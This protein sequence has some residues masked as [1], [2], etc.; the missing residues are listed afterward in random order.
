[1]SITAIRKAF[2]K[3]LAAMPD[4]IETAW[5][6]T[7]FTPTTGV[8]YQ[9]A[10]LMPAEPSNPTISTPGN[11][12]YRQEGYFQVSLR[13]PTNTGS[14]ACNIRAQLL[15]DT[16]YRGL[17]LTTEG[18]TSIVARTPEIAPGAVENDRYVINVRIRFYAN[19]FGV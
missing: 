4:A 17:S 2:E 5:E 3:A 18:V 19:I 15:R 16:F 12:H 6:N 14:G 13:Y 1:M 9:A 7:K 10:F 8:P 11:Q